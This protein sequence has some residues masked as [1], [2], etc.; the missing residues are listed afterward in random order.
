MLVQTSAALTLLTTRPGARAQGVNTPEGKL[1]YGFSSGSIASLMGDMLLE[2]LRQS[3]VANLRMTYMPGNS[4]RLAHETGKRAN[5]D[6]RSLLLASSTSITLFSQ[7]YGKRLNYEVKD[8]TPIAPLY[9]FTRMLVVGTCVP[10]SVKTVDD[11][12][13]WVQLNPTQS[14]VGIS[15]IGSG[16]HFAVMQLAQS[17][18]TVLRPVTYRGTGGA[19]KDLVTGNLPAAIILADQNTQ[20]LES[21]QIR[22]LAVTSTGRWPTWPDVPTLKELGVPECAF[23]EW[24][25]VLGPL[26]MDP[27]KVQSLNMGIRRALR[28]DNMVTAA[29]RVGL[30][31]LDMDTA[32]FSELIAKDAEQWRRVFGVTHFHGL[33]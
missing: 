32:Q 5:P 22:V 8:F 27:A 1:V 31:L 21:G 33:E 13:K 24:H 3:N 4:S 29:R 10:A 18:D 25:G 14:N 11:Y 16:S 20:H 28:Q 30:S 12:M 15:A 2:H 7:I 17:R 19:M 26:G 6:G 9:A 23:S